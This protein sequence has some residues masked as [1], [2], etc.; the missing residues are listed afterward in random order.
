MAKTPLLF[1]AALLAACDQHET[2]QDKIKQAITAAERQSQQ[3]A[4]AD[5]ARRAHPDDANPLR[6]RLGDLQIRELFFGASQTQGDWVAFLPCSQSCAG[7]PVAAANRIYL[8]RCP[9]LQQYLLTRARG[10]GFA[11]A[12]VKDVMDARISGAAVATP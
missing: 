3:Q 9:A 11:D 2:A 1:I 10:A 7:M 12:T 6:R 4:V 8:K 5:P